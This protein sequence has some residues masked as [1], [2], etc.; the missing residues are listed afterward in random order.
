MQGDLAKD[1]VLTQLKEQVQF[2]LDQADLNKEKACY[3]MVDYFQGMCDAFKQVLQL[4]EDAKG[5]P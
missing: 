5:G 3:E 4:I 1:A 2:R